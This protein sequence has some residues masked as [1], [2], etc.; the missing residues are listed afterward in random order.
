[1]RG[2]KKNLKSLC[3]GKDWTLFLDRDGV[4]NKK[5]EGDYVRS[6]SQ[7]EFIDGAIEGLKIL[8]KI[9]GRIIVVTNQ[10]GIGLGLMTENDLHKIHE[11]MQKILQENGVFIDKIYYCPHD[12]QKENCDCRKPKVGLALKA[13]TDFPEIDFKKSIVLGDSI[14][15]IEFGKSLDMITVFINQNRDFSSNLADLCFKNI[16][17]FAL[18]VKR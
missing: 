9:F 15:D 10:R 7:F 18:A 17:E 8:R 3:I 4:I 1:M 11:N 2:Q 5:I 12:Y 16:L 6:W 13:K 14:S